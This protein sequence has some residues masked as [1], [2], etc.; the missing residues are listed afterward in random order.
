MIMANF[1]NL[2]IGQL[3]LRL[4]SFVIRAPESVIFSTAILLCIA[5]VYLATGG[6]FGV[7]IMLMAAALG[8]VMTSFG[9]SP[10]IFIIAFFLGGRFEIA[11]SQSLVLLDGNPLAVINYPI[12]LALFMIAL[13]TM[14]WMLW[15]DRQKDI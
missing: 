13:V 5:G 7:I 1:A 14:V 11:L 2:F 9:F 10:V 15:A 12:A 3:G 8:Y 6:L 4:W